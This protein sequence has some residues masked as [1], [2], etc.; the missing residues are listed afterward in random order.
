M[1]K[2]RALAVTAIAVAIVVPCGILAWQL[3]I[4]KAR[5]REQRQLLHAQE[6]ARARLEMEL[7]RLSRKTEAAT[8]PKGLA[9]PAVA[10][11]P[12]AAPGFADTRLRDNLP[13]TRAI[14]RAQEQLRFWRYYGGLIRELDLSAKD[15]DRFFD[16][17]VG[18]QERE[19]D[20][21]IA[22]EQ[23]HRPADP[24]STELAQLDMQR[25]VE[26]DIEAFLGAD[27]FRT[28]REYRR[29]LGARMRV[30]QLAEQLDA[31]GV[32]LDADLW[33][34][35]IT[36]IAEESERVPAPEPA[37][38]EE[39]LDDFKRRLNWQDDYDRRVRARASDTL[40]SQRVTFLSDQQQIRAA[41][42]RSAL[43]METQARLAGL[44]TGAGFWYPAE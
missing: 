36:L 23:E 17:L 39:T 25:R 22:R 24:A 11:Q 12:S 4:E 27:K 19:N 33:G 38:G 28:Y 21:S 14:R 8:P 42:R 44:S 32:P 3:S 13:R 1:V 7:N 37:S 15:A 16:V 6:T 26:A 9:A 29:T 10:E 43:E 30:S 2:M 35:L 31:L 41:M 34:N 18:L 40:S 5:S 20:A